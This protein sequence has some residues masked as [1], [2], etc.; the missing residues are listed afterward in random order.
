MAPLAEL[1]PGSPE[2]CAASWHSQARSTVMVS[3][4]EAPPTHGE[5]V[6]GS[7]LGRAVS[8]FLE[9]RMLRY[10]DRMVAGAHHR[11]D[12]VRCCQSCSQWASC[13]LR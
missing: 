9:V 7:R 10:G 2:G 6:Q 8:W 5:L 1:L 13:R 12:A 3:W 4:C 11:P